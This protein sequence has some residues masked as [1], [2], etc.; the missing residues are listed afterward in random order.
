[1]ITE[2]KAKSILR[3][4][5]KIDSWFLT[6]YGLNLYRG[7][8]HNCVYC[9][10]RAET[11][12]VN[13]VFG[14]DIEVKTNA[15]EILEKELN[16][17]FKRKPMPKS[18][19]M[20]GGGVSDA[21]QPVEKKY[22]LA[23]KSLELIYKFAYPVHI[24]TK[25]TLI[26]RD[27]DLIKKIN[28]QNKAIVSFSF[29]STNDNISNFFEPGVPLPSERLKTIKKLKKYGISCGMFL[30]PVIPFISD[31]PKI[32]K[33]SI[34][35]AKNTGIDFVIFGAMT[36]KQ[37]QQKDYFMNTLKKH[38]PNLENQY[39]ILYQK[40]SK[41]GEPDYQ[42]MQSVNSVFDEIATSMKIPKRIPPAIFSKVINQNDQIIVFLQHLDYLLKLKNRKN[43]YGYASYKLA[44]INEPIKNLSKTQL[45]SINGIGDVTVKII[46]EIINTK[47]CKY[48]EKLI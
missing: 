21:Y 41:Y 34:E 18:F 24:L 9:D 16:P 48:Y 5:K 26:E 42:Y 35:D 47:K 2:I 13:G 15:V 30:M 22:K 32:I 11:Y 43:P 7:C 31:Y 19:M 45:K 23:R 36:L 3:K 37:G 6:H 46:N 8:L 39:E 28:K 38:F 20:L 44:Q 4:Q 29:S 27:I 17:E 10:G 25:S 1:M 14:K 12:R 33:K 40:S